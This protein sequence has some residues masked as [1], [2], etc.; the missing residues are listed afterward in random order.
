MIFCTEVNM[1]K[2][3]AAACGRV[4]DYDSVLAEETSSQLAMVMEEEPA[5]GA[6]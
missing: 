3:I 4:G 5:A 2:T 1:E 6:R